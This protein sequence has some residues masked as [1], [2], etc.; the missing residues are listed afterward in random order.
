[1]TLFYETRHIELQYYMYIPPLT[2]TV[3]PVT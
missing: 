1:M 3:A 2:G